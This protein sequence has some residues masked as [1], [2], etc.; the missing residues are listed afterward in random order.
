M[1]RRINHPQHTFSIR[2]RVISG[3][4]PPGNIKVYTKRVHPDKVSYAIAVDV[5]ATEIFLTPRLRRAVSPISHTFFILKKWFF[6]NIGIQFINNTKVRQQKRYVI[7]IIN[8]HCQSSLLDHFTVIYKKKFKQKKYAQIL[9][10]KTM[11]Y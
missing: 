7:I 5:K 6:V 1:G 3:R 8:F 2:I 4:F 10:N 11:F 9:K